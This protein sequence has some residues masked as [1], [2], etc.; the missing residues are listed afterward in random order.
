MYLPLLYQTL[1]YVASQRKG[2]KSFLVGNPV[3]L[4]RF[5]VVGEQV[6]QAS[7]KTPAGHGI[8]LDGDLFEQTSE[9]G[10]YEVWRKGQKQPAAYFAVNV[11]PKESDLAGLPPEELQAKVA[12]VTND[13]IQTASL[14][15]DNPGVHLEKHQRLWRF[16]ILLAIFLLVG[17]TWL[18]NRTYR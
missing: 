18:A 16:G 10:I 5:G 3:P 1:E 17:E 13:E 12:G 7:I 14:T 9:P 2:Q 11:D 4:Q 8:D 6:R 15:I